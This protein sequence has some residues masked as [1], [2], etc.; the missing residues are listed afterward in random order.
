MLFLGWK[1]QTDT[2]IT[3]NST[4]KATNTCAKQM[5]SFVYLLYGRGWSI[6]RFFSS[7]KRYNNSSMSEQNKGCGHPSFMFMYIDIY[8][9]GYIHIYVIHLHSTQCQQKTFCSMFCM[10]THIFHLRFSL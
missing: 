2:I 6:G 8:I 9:D 1:N 5:V 10:R 3:R 4:Q 7:I